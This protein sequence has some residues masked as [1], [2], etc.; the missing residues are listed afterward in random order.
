[1]CPGETGLEAGTTKAK[2]SL[3]SYE[4]DILFLA[5]PK[6]NLKLNIPE[7][8]NKGYNPIFIL[9]IRKI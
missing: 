8:E 4:E 1:M 6:L 2:L 5:G 3:S 7:R 9:L